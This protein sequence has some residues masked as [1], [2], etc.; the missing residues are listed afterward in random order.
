[1]LASTISWGDSV[2]R[3]KAFQSAEA[4]AAV[5]D[6]CADFLCTYIQNREASKPK[7]SRCSPLYS[8]AKAADI[9]ALL[10]A[11]KTHPSLPPT[12]KGVA[13]T[14]EPEAESST[15]AASDGEEADDEDA[16]EAAVEELQ[17]LPRRS[18]S[19]SAAELATNGFRMAFAQNSDSGGGVGLVVAAW[20]SVEGPSVSSGEQIQPGDIVLTMNDA[21]ASG[22]LSAEGKLDV[23]AGKP[24]TL[25]YVRRERISIPYL[26]GRLAAVKPKYGRNAVRKGKGKQTAWASHVRDAELLGG[27]PAQAARKPQ[28]SRAREHAARSVDEPSADEQMEAVLREA[29]EV[30]GGEEE[31][32]R[33][34]EETER[35]L[36]ARRELSPA[37]KEARDAELR[38]AVYSQ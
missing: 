31:I 34:V 24:V 19:F 35:R 30:G 11:L 17:S 9:D 25:E 16:L 7:A 29:A 15:A 28:R 37:E 8:A 6:D 33:I 10:E 20:L 32:A 14:A 3:E 21:D 36:L 1:V 23:P 18:C 38:E 22:M 12:G 5:R 13:A 27:S 4:E 2:R 26:G